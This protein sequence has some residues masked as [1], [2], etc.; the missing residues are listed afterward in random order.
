MFLSDNGMAFPFAKTNCYRHSTQTPW[1]V[2]WPGKVESGAV[3]ETHFI[4][5]VDFTPTVLEA[6]GIE[7]AVRL[8]GRSFLPLLIGEEQ[9][10]R[11]FVFTVFH[12]TSAQREYPMRA[13]HDEKFGY[14]FNAWADGETV[15][16]NE[17]QNGL[18][19]AAMQE[20]AKKDEAIAARLKMFL[21][22][23]QE[24][25]YDYEEDPDSL[26]N[27]ISDP[28]YADAL[29]LIRKKMLETL[30]MT[31]DPLADTYSER[32]FGKFEFT[33]NP[34]TNTP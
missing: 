27:L 19:F 33:E 9:E 2:R 3:D 30:V 28:E 5:G 11:D 6:A 22:R 10:R 24:E 31:Q 8:N 25:L 16:L 29:R 23:T 7:S 15:F 34:V 21:N 26:K 20:A 4:A 14:I 18:T 12:E 17:S 13:L 32:V 1:I